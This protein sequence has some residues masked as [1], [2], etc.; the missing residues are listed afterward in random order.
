MKV[1]L[2]YSLGF[3][4]SLNWITEK[5]TFLIFFYYFKLPTAFSF[6]TFPSLLSILFFLLYF[7]VMY[8]SVNDL[9]KANDSMLN[10]LFFSFFSE[11][12]LISETIYFF[13]P[14]EPL[15]LSLNIIYL[16][17]LY[18]SCLEALTL[19]I[20]KNYFL[21]RYRVNFSLIFLLISFR[22]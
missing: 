6:L 3:L 19:Y 8:H 4:W 7:N 15:L 2:K 5:W 1:I 11:T 20:S 17:K 22:T 16:I 13:K 14:K 10:F 18:I 12:S 21:V 9:W